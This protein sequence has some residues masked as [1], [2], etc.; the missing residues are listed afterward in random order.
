MASLPRVPP[1]PEPVHRG[2]VLRRPDL[3]HDVVRV[4]ETGWE[5]DVRTL[6]LPRLRHR[7]QRA[8]RGGDAWRTPLP[9]WAMRLS[10]R[11]RAEGA[12]GERAFADDGERVWWT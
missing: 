6:L 3:L 12:V 11:L 2:T 1:P 5:D 8:H 9:P 4:W 7:W 10:R